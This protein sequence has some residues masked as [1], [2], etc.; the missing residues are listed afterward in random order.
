MANKRDLSFEA[1]DVL[2]MFPTFVW[3]ADLTPVVHQSLNENII[4]ALDQLRRDE[5]ELAPGRAWQSER[6]LHKLDEFHELVSCINEATERVLEYLKV[7]YRAF[8]I[9]AFWANICMPG[10]E[11]KMHCHPNNFLSGVYYLATHKGAETINFHDPRSQTGIIRP[12]ATELTAENADQV[13]VTVKNGTLLVFPAWLP[14]SVDANE[15]GKPRISISFN[16]M[17]SA[18]AEELSKPLW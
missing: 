12:P 4:M 13:V 5:P 7:S 3:K 15:S 2:R 9:T 18:Y 16:T 14:H 11:H 6:A 8:E 10:A 1:A 17:F